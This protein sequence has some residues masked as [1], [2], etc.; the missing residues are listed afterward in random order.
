M[1][2]HSAAKRLKV[3]SV[4][5]DILSAMAVE[6]LQILPFSSALVSPVQ[7]SWVKEPHTPA[8]IK[9]STL[10][11][12]L[13]LHGAIHCPPSSLSRSTW[14]MAGGFFECRVNLP[15]W[16]I[17][18]LASLQPNKKTALG[19]RT[20]SANGKSAQMMW[21]RFMGKRADHTAH[22]YPPMCFPQ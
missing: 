5:I 19:Q 3:I 8:G 12:H 21:T 11:W 22:G 20:S 14:N 15:G 2:P 7:S 17:L 4:T 1:V 16:P 10:T 13:G 6:S 9:P 18:S